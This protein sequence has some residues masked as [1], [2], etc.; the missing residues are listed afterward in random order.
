ME[1]IRQIFTDKDKNLCE[2]VKSVLS[3]YSLP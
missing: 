3:V 2:S 1:R